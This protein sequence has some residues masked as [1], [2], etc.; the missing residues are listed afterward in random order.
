MSFYVIY[1]TCCCFR[2]SV[3]LPRWYGGRTK[4]VRCG[5]ARSP[6]GTASPNIK[7]GN[8]RNGWFWKSRAT[9]ERVERYRRL[10][11]EGSAHTSG[12]TSHTGITKT[13]TTTTHC[14]RL[15]STALRS[16]VSIN[17]PKFPNKQR[18]HQ[19]ENC[20]I[21]FSI[22]LYRIFPDR[23]LNIDPISFSRSANI[24]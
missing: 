17:R 19:R 7:R 16:T 5:C 2:Y 21:Y 13:T 15:F 14:L 20:Y 1:L 12:T 8:G 22:E 10:S 9:K 3:G 4:L 24:L 11:A 23:M 18:K 6:C